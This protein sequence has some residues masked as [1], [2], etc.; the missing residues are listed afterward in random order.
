[1]T[2]IVFFKED[3]E[4]VSGGM[5]L[6]QW[7]ARTIVLGKNATATAPPATPAI[8]KQTVKTPFQ[9]L[10]MLTQHD[11]AKLSYQLYATTTTTKTRTNSIAKPTTKLSTS[12]LQHQ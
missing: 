4:V 10:P 7:I 1:M 8:T 11:L 5:V 9:T 6:P 3:E 12:A 2:M